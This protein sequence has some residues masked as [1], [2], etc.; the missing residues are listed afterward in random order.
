MAQD[1]HAINWGFTAYHYDVPENGPVSASGSFESRTPLFS[2]NPDD[3][4]RVWSLM[5]KAISDH[6]PG[7]GIDAKIISQQPILT[8]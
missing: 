2:V 4:K 1:R 3:L 6:G 7:I 5:Q 8:P